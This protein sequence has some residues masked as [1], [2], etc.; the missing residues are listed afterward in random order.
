MPNLIESRSSYGDLIKGV[1]IQFMEVFNEEKEAYVSPLGEMLV[2]PKNKKTALI[3]EKTTDGAKV[4]FEGKT[5]TQLT[6]LT[7]EGADYATDTRYFGYRTDM[8]PQKFTNSVSV[9]EEAREDTDR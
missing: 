8:I 4:H 3:K 1:G 9:T 6:T 7:A 2:N 5:G